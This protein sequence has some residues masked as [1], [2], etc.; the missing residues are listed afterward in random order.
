MSVLVAPATVVAQTSSNSL[1]RLTVEP[2]DVVLVGAG[3]RQQ[4][5][6]TGHCR[7]GAVRDLTHAVRWRCDRPDIVRVQDGIVHGL[8]DGAARVTAEVGSLQAALSVAV[9]DAARPQPVS[10][11]NDVMAVL[12]RA[13]CNLGTCHGNFNGKNGFRL[14]LR[15]DNP[16][17]D[18]DSLLRDTQGRRTSLFDPGRSLILQK[19]TG[20]APHEGGI[21]FRKNSVEYGILERWIR[22]GAKPDAASAPRLTR[23]DVWPRE[24]V[25]LHGAN[26]Q[27]L[28]T[29]AVLSDGSTRDVTHLTVFEPTVETVHVT[30]GGLV[31]SDKPCEVTVV[32]RY[33]DRREP[34]MLAFVPERPNFRWPAVAAHN[35]IDEHVFARLKALQV[36]PSDVADDATFLRRAYLDVC[37]ILPTPDEARRFLA[38]QAPD[39][40]RRLVDRLLERPEYADYWAMKWAD[41][42]RNEEKAVDAKGVRLFQRWLRQC[43]SDDMPLDRFARQLLTARGSTYDRPEANYYRT[44]LDPQKAAETTAQ[45][46]LGVRVACAKCH[47]HPFDLWTQEDYHGLSAFFARVRTRMIDNQRRDRLDKHEL[48]GEMIVWHD[49]EGDVPHPQKGG[50]IAP[51]LPGLPGSKL[52]DG[53]DRLTALADWVTAA[54]NP[55][56]ARVMANRI[57]HHLLGRG[58]VEPVDDFRESNPPS[59]E[60]LLAALAKDLVASGWRQKH[61]IRAIMASRTYQASSTT[62]PTNE[63]DLN[64]SHVEP[65]VLQAEA[66]LDAISQVT[67]VP[68]RFA[69]H[70]LGTRAAQLP[71]VSGA[72]TFLKAFGRPDRLLACECERQATTTLNQAFQMINGESITRKVSES[73]RVERW[74]AAKASNDEVIAELYLAALARVPTAREREAIGPRLE[75]APDRRAA[76]EDLLWA[77]INTKEFLLRR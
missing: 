38:D 68:E 37:G 31:R 24:R 45:L 54:D 76:L 51:R 65:R 56:F 5:L 25:L 4:L 55:Y 47:N 6:V 39:K 59:N 75:R 50:P 41:L 73:P 32:A 62:K 26:E 40:R 8:A 12:S 67:E 9:R 43:V 46:F 30:P 34:V 63:D 58:V 61:L 33:L 52:A 35:V 60:P 22:G 42:L 15:G 44:N 21:R 7:D 71:G 23:L 77:M 72:P 13:G 66:L 3:A 11:R 48:V 28:V 1:A 49:R 20:Q 17:F 10:F 69:G 36:E 53:A 64:F 27:Q 16:E 74:L 19:P 57:W 2:A 14:S 18:L 29:R 70:P